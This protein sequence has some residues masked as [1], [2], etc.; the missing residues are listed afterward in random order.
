M[1]A[2]VRFA[3]L[4]RGYVATPADSSATLAELPPAG[5][6]SCWRHFRQE[7]RM[8]RHRNGQARP[9]GRGPPRGP[10]GDWRNSTRASRRRKSP[11]GWLP[12]CLRS[13]NS[14]ELRGLETKRDEAWRAYD[15]ASRDVDRQKDALLDEISRRLQQQT[16]CE[17]LFTLRWRVA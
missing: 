17:T 8:V 12:T 11:P 13:L 7:R 6:P 4:D 15:A 1:P 16:T 10:Q 5:K 2:I 3:G 9:L 14:S